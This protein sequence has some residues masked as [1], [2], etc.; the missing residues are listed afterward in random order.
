MEHGG[1]C[2]GG[3]EGGSSGRRWAVAVGREGE[4]G[5][6]LRWEEDEES[7]LFFSCGFTMNPSS[8]MGL[9]GRGGIHTALIALAT[10]RHE[11][12]RRM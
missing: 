3:M 9:F 12:R 10:G 8:L 6:S 1:K 4:E 11:V 2:S 7:N 5:A